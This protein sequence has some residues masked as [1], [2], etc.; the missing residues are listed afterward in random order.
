M[1]SRP[2]TDCESLFSW[3]RGELW[4]EDKPPF[5]Y[6]C[7]KLEAAQASHPDP[8]AQWQL[9][10]AFC[11]FLRSFIEHSRDDALRTKTIEDLAECDLDSLLAL[12]PV[13]DNELS[14]RLAGQRA[15][16]SSA[17]DKHLSTVALEK[18]PDATLVAQASIDAPGV[19]VI[20]GVYNTQDYAGETLESLF[21]QDFA[22]FEII[23]IDDGS[24]DDSLQVLEEFAAR[25]PRI[26]VAHQN[27]QGVSRARNVGTELAR[28]QYLYYMDSDDLL[29]RSALR[30][31]LD[32]AKQNDLDVVYIDGYAFYDSEDLRNAYPHFEAAYDRRLDYGVL[33]NG[34]DLVAALYRN[35]DDYV[36]TWLAMY[37]KS[38]LESNSIRFIEHVLHEDNAF[39]FVTGVLSKRSG[40]CHEKLLRRRVRSNSIMTQ[41]TTFSNAYGY[42][43]CS[44]EMFRAYYSIDKDL[45][46]ATRSALKAFIFRTLRNSAAALEKIPES[47]W[48]A[49]F[50]LPEDSFSVKYAALMPAAASLGRARCSAKVD[51]FRS[52]LQASR[53]SGE[54]KDRRIDCLITERDNAR[55]ELSKTKLDFESQS[56]ELA[57][58]TEQRDAA[59]NEVARIRQSKS[60]KV[61]NALMRPFIALKRGM[62]KR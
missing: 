62:S 1:D 5:E 41:P 34:A 6:A 16:L 31:M 46:P 19:S 9:S 22:N 15:F 43:A 52:Q 29:E 12:P 20:I 60:F 27:N 50:G 39:F 13:G 11:A 14:R 10:I 38:F 42:Y 4:A 57:E 30:K 53:K 48:G 47:E 54:E 45:S 58:V 26:T 61:G 56:K 49:V 25:D 2:A 37:R 23:C 24:T 33:D 3:N 18:T 40:H 51:E 32:V 55:E 36:P 28:G 44:L 59:L 35:G 17:I 8:S 7:D 21:D